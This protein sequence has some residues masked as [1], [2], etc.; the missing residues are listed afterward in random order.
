VLSSVFVAA[1]L[2]CGGFLAAL[3]TYALLD[4]QAY[5]IEASACALG[6][7]VG[8]V[9]ML[10]GHRRFH[11]SRVL[12]WTAVAVGCALG[13]LGTW[14]F[15][16]AREADANLVPSG[17]FSGIENVFAMGFGIIMV[18]ATVL[19]VLGGALS[20]VARMGAGRAVSDAPRS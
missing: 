5:G 8:P 2:S 9:V 15:L 11:R 12:A 3:F 17:P 14:L 19:A 1:V 6:F 18:A 13:G 16:R 20:L 4:L 7:V 10:L